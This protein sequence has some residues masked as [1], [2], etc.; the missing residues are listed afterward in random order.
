MH[1]ACSNKLSVLDMLNASN[2]LG[3]DKKCLRWVRILLHSS[4]SNIKMLKLYV[5]KYTI[6]V[7]L[8][9]NKK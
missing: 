6:Y 8:G 2:S 5:E 4:Y 1:I 7:L 9:Y 3:D